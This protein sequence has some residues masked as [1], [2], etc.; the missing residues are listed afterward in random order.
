MYT[1]TSQ[2]SGSGLRQRVGMINNQRSGWWALWRYGIWIAIM[3]VMALACRHEPDSNDRLQKGPKPANLTQKLV[4]ELEANE[5][6]YRHVALFRNRLGTQ[7][8]QGNPVVLHLKGNQFLLPDDYKFAS[9][10]YINGRQELAEK[11]GTLSPEFVKEVYVLHQFENLATTVSTDK[12]YRIYIQTST[13]PVAFD[14]V[15]K[16]FFTLLQAAAISKYP[17]GESFSFNMNQ[18]LEATFFHNKNALVER[19]K[20]QHLRVYDEFA[21]T[22]DVFVNN[23]PSTVADVETIHVRE[24]ARLYTQER[25][26]TAWFRANH[27]SPRFALFIQTAPKRAKRDSSYYVFSPFYSGDF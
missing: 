12:P 16:K 3:G 22:V 23:L 27:P 18:L 4:K 24:V 9:L 26:Y 19:T 6:W 25:P 14:P 5:S 17:T 15:R 8:I 13:R 7:M 11:L 20:N 21:K 2:F 1:F 10:V